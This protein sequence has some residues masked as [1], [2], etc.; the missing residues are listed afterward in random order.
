MTLKFIK[1]GLFLLALIALQQ[2][3]AVANHQVGQLHEQSLVVSNNNLDPSA[4][5]YMEIDMALVAEK[6]V[7]KALHGP[8]PDQRQARH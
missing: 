3:I 6:S 4:L 1:L 7:R 8:G 2:L 5:F